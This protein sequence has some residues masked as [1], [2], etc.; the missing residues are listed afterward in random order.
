MSKLDVTELN[1]TVFWCGGSDCRDE[2]GKDVHKAMRHK[3][4]EAGLKGHVK[5]VKTHCTGQ[6]KS[7]PVVVVCGA[8][9]TNAG[10]TVW[11]C[12]LK[13]DDAETIVDE[14]LLGDCPVLS[15]TFEAHD[16]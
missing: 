9:E 3:V 15:K 6:C 12:K 1:Y 8:G 5:F 13:T 16:E 4:R 11:Y 10:K 7:A 14:H 2:G